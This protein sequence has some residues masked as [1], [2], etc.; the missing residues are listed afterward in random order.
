MI[1]HALR[2][3][4]CGKPD[5]QHIGPRRH[6]LGD[7]L[8]P[9]M[10]FVDH[11]DVGL[12]QRTARQRLHQGYLHRHRGVRQRMA[13][14]NDADVEDPFAFER[15]N[16]LV[17]KTDCRHGEAKS[18]AFGDRAPGDLGGNAGLSG[19]GGELQNHATASPEKGSAKFLKRM[20]LVRTEWS[21][22][23][24]VGLELTKQGHS[25]PPSVVR[26]G[27]SSVSVRSSQSPWSGPSP[28]PSPAPGSAFVAQ[29]LN[30][31]SM[32]VAR[33]VL[34]E[35]IPARRFFSRFA[36]AFAISALVAGWVRIPS[37][38]SKWGRSVSMI[39]AH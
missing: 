23:G 9:L 34:P 29:P 2:P 38:I 27:R 35:A 5:E 14:L 16:R 36:L 32:A 22:L 28:S 26:N 24:R 1:G 25:Q 39:S 31:C 8:E 15:L 10:A 12:G 3:G 7:Y 21:D 18:V 4:R 37:L 33:L 19:A 13:G 17:D 6:P 20:V 30:T 11:H